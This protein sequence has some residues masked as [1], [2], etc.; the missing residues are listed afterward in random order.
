MGSS[1]DRDEAA[2]VTAFLTAVLADQA[3]G[4]L[5]SLAEYQASYPGFEAVVAREYALLLEDSD[6]PGDSARRLAEVGCD[7]RGERY[8]EDGVIGQG[9]LGTV[10]RIWEHGLRR[11]VAMKRLRAEDPGSAELAPFVEEAQVAAQLH[12]PGVLPVHELGVDSDGHVYF[13]MDLVRGRTFADVIDC[14][15]TG[16][17][18]WSLTRAIEVVQRVCEAVGYAPGWTYSRRSKITPST[19]KSQSASSREQEAQL[20]LALPTR[21][22]RFGF[23]GRP[24]HRRRQVTV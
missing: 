12:H 10:L 4:A 18:G 13:T 22:A 16:R 20:S 7:S 21:R 23:F 2:I 24:P 17:D 11:H 8:R 9:G 5:A 3:R 14:V 6:A 1:G 19:L 15:A